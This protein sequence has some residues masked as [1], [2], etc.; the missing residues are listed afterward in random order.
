[1]VGLVGGLAPDVGPDVIESSGIPGI[2][3]HLMLRVVMPQGDVGPILQMELLAS[4]GSGPVFGGDMAQRVFP[5]DFKVCHQH[6]VFLGAFR[7][8]RGWLGGS[9]RLMRYR[10]DA[11]V[12]LG[13]YQ[14]ARLIGSHVDT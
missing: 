10:K 5:L 6:L 12:E 1:M 3:C 13:I 14:P 7:L 4:D 9:H 2:F 11:E 8:Q